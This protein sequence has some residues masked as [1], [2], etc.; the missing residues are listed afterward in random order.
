M[1][2]RT[3]QVNGQPLAECDGIEVGSKGPRAGC[4]PISAAG[5]LLRYA[6]ERRTD[7]DVVT[8][9]LFDDLGCS[10]DLTP[11]DVQVMV[12]LLTGRSQ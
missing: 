8:L 10:I 7:S 1:S 3:D 2:H 9:T 4:P 6:V 11:A 5:Q 12:E